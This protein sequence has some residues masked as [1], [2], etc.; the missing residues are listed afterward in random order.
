M[1]EVW[2][3]AHVE[4]RLRVALKT[5]RREML[6]NNEV[7]ARFSREAFLLGRVQSEHVA[8]VFDFVVDPKL[9]PVLVTEFVEGPSLATVIESKRMSV[10]E[11][12]DLAIDVVTGLRELHRAHVVH[13]DV[14]PANILLRPIGD[15]KHR[16]V[17][18]DFGVSRLLPEGQSGDQLLTEITTCDRA[19]GTM[20][21]MAPEQILSSRDATAAADLYAIGAILYR[22]VAGHHAFRDTQG[23][24]LLKR[25]LGEA[26]PPLD[27]GRDDR[28]AKGFEEVVARSLS[29]APEDRYEVTDEMLAD[30]LLLRDTARRARSASS[31]PPAPR[32]SSLAP[33][34]P[35]APLAKR[36]MRH[37]ARRI[38]AMVAAGLACIALGTVVGALAASRHAHAAPNPGA[39]TGC[40]IEPSEQTGPGRSFLVVC[41]DAR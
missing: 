31:V 2:E 1:G 30:L 19:L 11:G 17:F 26:A 16:A 13:R 7:L 22:A 20:E 28:V 40:H 36:L 34:A 23:I 38:V 15:G 6:G 5:L 35:L 10:E 21:Y 37:P 25:K 18:V 8:R 4:L 9:G 29:R 24:D 39:T 32:P 14:K 33:L 27:T 3:G 41:D 12:I